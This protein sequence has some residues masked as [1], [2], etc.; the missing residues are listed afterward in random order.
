MRVWIGIGIIVGLLL[1]L[2]VILLMSRIT[3]KVQVRKHGAEEAITLDI[4]LL[5]N[6]VNY[7]YEVPKI[8]FDNFKQGLQVESQQTGGIAKDQSKETEQHIGV[9]RLQTWAA[10]YKDMK[11]STFNFKGW[12][13]DFIKH[14]QVT[15]LDWAT[16]FALKEADQT[17]ILSGSLWALKS[18]LV[19][20]LSYKVHMTRPPKLMIRPRFGVEPQFGTEFTCIGQLRLGFMLYTLLRLTLRIVR[21]KGGM[22]KWKTVLFGR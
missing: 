14:L 8:V 7:H 6:W 11:E 9:E 16:F 1:L 18:V 4:G 15:R 20:Y 22:K 19:G 12:Y 10:L 21:I 5:F 13:R 3:I 17:A 2:F